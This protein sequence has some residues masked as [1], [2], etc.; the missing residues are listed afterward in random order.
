[1]DNY[2]KLRDEAQAWNLRNLPETVVSAHDVIVAA[3]GLHSLDEGVSTELEF[4]ERVE[5]CLEKIAALPKADIVGKLYAS[6]KD[7]ALVDYLANFLESFAPKFSCS[8]RTPYT[9][10]AITFETIAG[11]DKVKDDINKGFINPYF[12][13]LLFKKRS[14]GMLLYGPPGTGKTLF[15]KA[16]SVQIPNTILFDPTIGEIRGKFEGETEKNI[17]EIFACASQAASQRG[18]EYNSII[19]FDEIDS[20]AGHKTTESMARTVNAL[21]QMMDGTASFSN[22]SVLGATNYPWKIEPAI[23]RRFTSKI[24]VDLPDQ[25]A[26]AAI[27]KTALDEAYSVEGISGL[28]LLATYGDFKLEDF[29][30]KAV[31]GFL[32]TK[33]GS[34]YMEQWAKGRSDDPPAATPPMFG[35]SPSD[36]SKILEEAISSA[37]FD[38]LAYPTA[39]ISIGSGVYLLASK[40]SKGPSISTLDPGSYPKV[41]AFNFNMS[42]LTR[43]MEKLGQTVSN[44]DYY[45]YLYYAKYQS[46]PEEMW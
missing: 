18:P 16:C 17:K 46:L 6:P 28:K 4:S 5:V 31:P 11:N 43:A 12:F 25:E 37:N 13:P 20:I 26:I 35:Y 3:T 21:L 19:F 38:A 9:S 1:M 44:A 8:D 45:K 2:K 36:I 24:L 41:V 22:V 14:K 23:L 29:L 34:N 15:A 40:G 30:Q 32:R 33:A 42:Y 27:I 7:Q 39:E 10:K